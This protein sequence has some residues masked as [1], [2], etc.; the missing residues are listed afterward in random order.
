MNRTIAIAL[1]VLG[2]E[3]LLAMVTTIRI[4]NFVVFDISFPVRVVVG[5]V[6]LAL[7]L[8]GKMGLRRFRKDLSPSEIQP[9]HSINPTGNT[10]RD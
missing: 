10:V 5:S 9:H 7:V 1:Q 4:E 8:M 3:C 6:G 2:Y